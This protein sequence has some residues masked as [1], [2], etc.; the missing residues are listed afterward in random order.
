MTRC[1]ACGLLVHMKCAPPLLPGRS[2]QC[3]RCVKLDNTD[4]EEGQVDGTKAKTY[5]LVPKRF[6][7]PSDAHRDSV[8]ESLRRSSGVT[9][10]SMAGVIAGP[11]GVGRGNT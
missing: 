8:R 4:V 9:Y 2:I 7:K 6:L 1:R 10:D 3:P 5:G 11:I